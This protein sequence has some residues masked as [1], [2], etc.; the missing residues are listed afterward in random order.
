MLVRYED[1]TG[2]HATQAFGKLFTH[3]DICLP[4]KTLTELLTDHSFERMSGRRQG[5]EDVKS[6]YRK[7]KTGD[8][9]EQLDDDLLAHFGAV[10]GDLLE[11]LHYE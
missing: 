10:A 6:H 5:E 8:W 9:R 4:E 1:L 2:P 11:A 3:C 7:G